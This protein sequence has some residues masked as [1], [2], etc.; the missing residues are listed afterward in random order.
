MTLNCD[1]ESQFNSFML[2]R[3]L[4]FYSKDLACYI[5]STA[6]SQVHLINS[7]QD[8]YEYY[9][10]MLP[11]CKFKKIEYIKKAKK[12]EEK[13]KQLTP[14]FMSIREYNNNVDLAK[15]LDI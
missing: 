7:K 3:W 11:K 6:N 10:N 13:E 14:E 4:S 12:E 8:Q 15:Q 1:D 9:Y 5:N 2:N